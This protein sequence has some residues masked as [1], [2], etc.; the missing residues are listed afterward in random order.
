[1]NNFKKISKSTKNRVGGV[2][3]PPTRL[4]WLL[5]GIIILSSFIYFSPPAGAVSADKGDFVILGREGQD[6]KISLCVNPGANDAVQAKMKPGTVVLVLDKTTV[7]RKNFYLVST[8]G[9]DGG[10]IGWVSEDYIYEI[11]TEPLRE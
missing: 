10:M 7:Q 9:K 6:E 4:G 8:V 2:L 1:M 5:F 11:T 3:T